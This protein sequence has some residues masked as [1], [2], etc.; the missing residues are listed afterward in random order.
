M[1]LKNV[2]KKSNVAAKLAARSM[3]IVPKK[4]LSEEL[5]Q[6]KAEFLEKLNNKEK[7]FPGDPGHKVISRDEALEYRNKLANIDLSFADEAK[8]FKPGDERRTQFYTNVS[9]IENSDHEVIKKVKKKIKKLLDQELEYLG[10]TNELKD[11]EEKGL[12]E[13]TFKE[14]DVK[15]SFFYKFDNRKVERNRYVIDAKSPGNVHRKVMYAAPHEHIHPQHYVNLDNLTE[16]DVKQLY[17]YYTLY[18]DFHVG[19]VRRSVEKKNYVPPQF[20]HIAFTDTQETEQNIDNKFIEYYHH[21]REPTRTWR[22]QTQEIDYQKELDS[23]PVNHHPHHGAFTENEVEWT[24]DQ[25]FPHVANRLGYPI[26]AESPLEKIIGLERAPAHPSYQF[27]PFVQTP[28]M[29]PDPSLNFEAAETI[30]EN[31]R[32]GEWVRMWK[33]LFTCTLPF[34]PAFFTFEIYQNDGLPSLDW[35][36]DTGSWHMP[37]KQMQDSGNA[38]LYSMRYCDEHDYMNIQYALKRAVIRPAHTMYQ[39]ALLSMISSLNF[40]YATRMRYNKDK[41]LVFVDKPDGWFTDKEYVYEVHHLESMVPGPVGAY[42]HLGMGH[43]DGITTLLCMDTKQ[44]IKL[45][46]DPKYWNLEL[47]DDFISQTRSLWPNLCD[48][49]EGR[50]IQINRK[51]SDKDVQ[52]YERIERELDEAVEKH[53]K[54]TPYP[55]YPEQFYDDLKKRRKSI[56]EAAQ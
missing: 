55:S 14:L 53:G 47:R 31:K 30:Y 7:K 6:V 43:K 37:V 23:L 22:S 42:Q 20:N 49:Y 9:K 25:K 3:S 50:V 26:M 28:S 34:W 2:Y 48:K 39:L 10:F 46:N 45:Y 5:Q 38:N 4:E 13:E 18:I 24:E 12:V 1:L 41:D 11:L 52:T 44:Q 36:S 16:E 17:A 56:S 54:I 32:V 33:W 21:W 51:M 29:D 35:L 15:Q 40:N 19:Q 27:Q 8:N